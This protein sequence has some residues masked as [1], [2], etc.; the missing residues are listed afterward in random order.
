MITISYQPLKMNP[1]QYHMLNPYHWSLLPHESRARLISIS[2][3]FNYNPLIHFT[4][5]DP[6]ITFIQFITQIIPCLSIHKLHTSYKTH[7][8]QQ[9]NYQFKRGI[10]PAA[11]LAQ[12]KSP[13]SG[14][15]GI[16]AQAIDPCLGEIA[17]NAGIPSQA[18]LGKS[19][20]AWARQPLVQQWRPSP[21]LDHN[22]VPSLHSSSLR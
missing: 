15:R 16:L 22:N 21:G 13:R 11:Y 10:Q 9:S 4:C 20:L 2:C 18:R 14:E 12:A 17:T 3:L 8:N 19:W 5:Q 7:H 1:H 6:S